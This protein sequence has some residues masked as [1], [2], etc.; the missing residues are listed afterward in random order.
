MSFSVQHSQPTQKGRKE[1]QPHQPAVYNSCARVSG[2]HPVKT[3]EKWPDFPPL[4]HEALRLRLRTSAVTLVAFSWMLP[5]STSTRPAR[6]EPLQH[7]S[8]MLLQFNFITCINFSRRYGSYLHEA[9]VKFA[10]PQASHTFST[11]LALMNIRP[12]VSQDDF[13]RCKAQRCSWCYH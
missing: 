6:E 10:P 4:T 3:S 13:E 11:G 2:A 7:F 8:S 5:F 1:S 12:A 9:F